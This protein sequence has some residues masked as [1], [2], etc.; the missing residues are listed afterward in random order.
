M[1]ILDLFSGIG[2]FSIAAHLAGFEVVAHCEIEPFPQAVLRHR[3]PEIP[4]FD[5][6][7]TLT[8]KSFYEKTGLKKIDIVCGGSPCQGFS[9]AGLQ[10]GFGDNRSCLFSEQLRVARELGAKFFVW[11]NVPGAL[12]SNQG[13]D[14]ARVLSELTGWNLDAR[15]WGG[16]GFVRARTESDYSVTYRILDT[17]FFGIP[18]RRRRIYLVASLGSTPRPE[19]LFEREGVRGDTAQGVETRKNFAASP[20]KHIAKHFGFVQHGFG[21]FCESNV[22]GTVKTEAGSPAKGDTTLIAATLDCSY[23]KRYGCDNQHVDAGCPNFVIYENNPQD[24]RIKDAGGVSPTLSAKMGTG[25][26]N[27]PIC[28]HASQ[29]P[30]CSTEHAHAIGVKSSQAVCIAENVIGRKVENGGNGIGA[31]EELSYTLNT[32]GVHGVAFSQNQLG[33]IRGGDISPTLNTNSNASGRNVPMLPDSFG[34]R[35]LTP[36][37]CERLQ[38]FPDDWTKISYRGKESSTCPDGPRYKACGNA[39]TVDVAEWVLRRL[40]Q[41]A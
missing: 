40:A 25:G 21:K 15:K 6:I 19:I 11:E 18:Q 14:F 31:Q 16:A 29:D 41:Y 32:T 22:S 17:R 13:R 39:V 33:E 1:K 34:V 5:D 9:I 35:R 37:E 20:R 8:K 30:I 36:R 10:R 2:G 24:S 7:R 28:V 27:T 4:I 12:S 38:G 26:N 3:F 23:A